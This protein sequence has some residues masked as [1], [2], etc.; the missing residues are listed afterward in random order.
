MRNIEISNGALLHAKR[1]TYEIERS[2]VIR[3]T[4]ISNQS[5]YNNRLRLH[6]PPPA[7]PTMDAVHYSMH[8]I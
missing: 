8:R 5:I 4:S 7:V 6:Q 1:I 3:V 2:G